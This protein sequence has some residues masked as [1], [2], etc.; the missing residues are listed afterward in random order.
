MRIIIYDYK[1]DSRSCLFIKLNDKYI[2]EHLLELL[3]ETIP[4]EVIFCTKQS[5]QIEQFIKTVNFKNKFN[6]QIAS[7]VDTN[8]TDVIL[9]ANW[10]YDKRHLKKL[11]KDKNTDTSSAVIWKIEKQ[12]D[13]KKAEELLIRADWNPIGRYINVKLGMSIA[14]ILAKTP[15]VPNQITILCF[16]FSILA[17][18]FFATNRYPLLVLAAILVQIHFTLD[19]SDGH[20]ARLKNMTSEFGGWSDGVVDKVSELFWYI[21]IS[22]GVY[23]KYNRS[24]FLVL[25]IFVVLGNLMIHHISYLKKTFLKAK[26]NIVY[27]KK[28]EHL[29]AKMGVVKSIYWFLEQWDVRAYIITLFAILNRLEIVLVYFALD[30]NIRW[31]YNCAKV[32]FLH[33]FSKRRID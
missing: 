31:I 22:W 15:L 19:V 13:I 10:V 27:G 9:R 26:T 1:I 2:I 25:G 7:F 23:L 24:I 4:Q 32:I 20:L 30:Y 8:P 6:I 16:V 18:L 11:I 21:G 33:H 28:A 12:N 5:G 14:R 3:E 17:A 29:L